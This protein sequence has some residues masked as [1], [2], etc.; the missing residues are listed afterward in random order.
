MT[1][2]ALSTALG[3]VLLAAGPAT[4]QDPGAVPRVVVLSW[5]A[6]GADAGETAVIE[7][8]LR[9][10]GYTKGVSIR[11]EHRSAGADEHRLPAMAREAASL[12]PAVIVA[13]GTKAA[14][15]AKQA[16]RTVPIVT[17]AGDIVAAGLVKNL[18]RPEGN[19]TVMSFVTVDLTLKR[20]E[21]LVERAPKL[22]RITLPVVGRPNPTFEEALIALRAGA[23]KNGIDVRVVG[24]E[25]VEEIKGVFAKVGGTPAVGILVQPSPLLDGRAREIGR[26]AADHR[27]VAMFS[28]KEYA[29]GGGL[30]AYGPDLAALWRRAVIYVDRILRGAQ[31]AD[32]PVEQPTKFEL[33]INLKTARAIGL[34]VPPA[35]LLRAD[36]VVEE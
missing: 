33:V 25:R 8:S 22:R 1:R 28:W 10:L 13:V 14:L 5:A 31:P 7:E 32:L 11:I 23:G 19:I 24:V 35:V 34:T 9:G 16:T 30:V 21:L 18:R 12:N 26:L 27:L 6:V 3:A 2:R 4:G 20:F 36:R 29:E 17:V 15:A